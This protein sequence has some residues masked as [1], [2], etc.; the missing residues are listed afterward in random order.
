M[1]FQDAAS[2]VIEEFL[3]F[4]DFALVVLAFILGLVG[5]IMVIAVTN[6]RVV[7]GLLEGQTL[8]ALWTA[9]PALV[10]IQLAV[11]SLLLLYSLDEATDRQVTLKAVG[12][13]WY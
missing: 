4:H 3:F 8:E 6:R 2:P 11:P 7:T 1:G 10:L 12:H 9:L 13:Q 5:Y